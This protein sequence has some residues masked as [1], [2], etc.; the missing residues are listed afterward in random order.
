MKRG[1]KRTPTNLLKLRGSWRAD[2]HGSA[3][4]VPID[5]PIMPRSLKGEA[6]KEWERLVP[7]LVAVNI[8]TKLDRN[9]LAVYCQTFSQWQD[10][11]KLFES[12]RTSI[13]MKTTNGNIIQNPLIGVMN[14]TADRL[15]KIGAELGL[16]PTSRA[17]LRVNKTE[18]S[19]QVGLT[20]FQKESV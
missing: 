13:I 7:Q 14:K 4:E 2:R 20:K 15:I 17:G 5:K 6:R 18:R 12:V 1:R 8:V 11:I 3:P 10:T 19:E 16:S 9:L